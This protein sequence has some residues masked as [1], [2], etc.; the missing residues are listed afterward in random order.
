MNISKYSEAYVILKKNYDGYHFSENGKDVY[1]PYSLL[2]ALNDNK[3]TTY[4]F[5]NAT[6]SS[7]LDFL[8]RFPITRALEYDGIEVS[9][10]E[11][12]RLMVLLAL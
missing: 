12:M 3:I 11:F 6:S 9:E 10:N 1:A 5:D 2:N 8:T 7:L 4:R